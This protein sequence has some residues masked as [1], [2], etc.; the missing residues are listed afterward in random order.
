MGAGRRPGLSRARGARCA[1]LA[2]RCA[3]VLDPARRSRARS[4]A[5][6]LGREGRVDMTPA[7]IT[8][9]IERE[10]YQLHARGDGPLGAPAILFSNSLGATLQS[11]EPQVAQLAE[12]FFVVRYDNRGH[13]GSSAP[14]GDYTMSE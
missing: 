4:R 6:E 1:V 12:R 8:R 5:R 7:A 2:R 3:R 10:G 11:W 9:A 13:G 14:A